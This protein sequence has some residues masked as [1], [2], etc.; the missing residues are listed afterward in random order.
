PGQPDAAPIRKGHLPGFTL[1]RSQVEIHASGAISE[2][3][4][5]TFIDQDAYVRQ[6]RMPEPPLLLVDRVTGIDAE[7]GV[8]STGTIWTET[9]ILED[10]W[11]LH[12]GRMPAGILIESGQADLM[13]ISY[14]GADLLN[15]SD[16]VYRL[17]GCQL[18]FEDDLPAP[19]DTL[20][21]EI[22]VD[23]HAKQKDIRLFFFHYDCT[24]GGKP[25]IKVRNG[26][27]GFFTDEELADS[28]GVLWSPEEVEPCADPR[29][30]LPVVVASQTSFDT[31][32]VRAFAEGRPWDC[33][34]PEFS[35]AK[36]HTRTPTIQTGDMLLI[37]SVTELA[38]T[39]GPWGRGYLRAEAPVSSDDWFFAG[40]F[41]NDAC[42]PGTLM[43]EGC[44]QAL[45][46]TMAGLGFTLHHDGWRFQ[47]VTDEPIEM[48]CRGQVTPSSRNVV[49]EVFIEEIIAGPRPTIYA[50][51]LCTVDG[52]KAFHARRVGLQLVPDWPLG[53]QSADDQDHRTVARV[54]TLDG[55]FEFGYPSL[56]ACALGKPSDAFGPMYA[57]F[58]GPGRVPRLPGPPY[59]FL[60]RVT[61]VTG[62]IGGMEVGSTVD[63]EYDIPQDA[64][65]FDDNGARSMPFAVL[66]EAA[67]QPCGWLA[68]YIGSALTVDSELAFRN[69]DGTGT[70]H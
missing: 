40:H 13:L 61:D 43:F 35:L 69:L 65:Y 14:M 20:S 31:E 4:G 53:S 23:G 68:S 62:P 28:G 59:H 10:S 38:A 22:H 18:T 12:R 36:T 56:L 5:P 51:L 67:L 57:R 9:D 58:D 47:T 70:V 49:Y 52:Q 24:V 34:G 33:F 54:P 55:E 27:A 7:P 6:V 16:R 11:Y 30:D 17:L 48:V 2:I 63:V 21:Y 8:H 25:R 42:M 1:D 46:F 32:A 50:D 60:S 45:S 3:F 41:K 44:L 37:D 26:Q 19:G 39:G 66:L 64:W 15:K 29:L